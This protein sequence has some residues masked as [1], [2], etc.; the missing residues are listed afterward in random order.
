MKKIIVL[1]MSI[2]LVIN[3]YAQ[4]GFGGGG[5]GRGGGGFGGGQGGP[6]GGGSGGRPG[7]GMQNMQEEFV[8]EYFPEI[9]GLS[10]KQKKSVEKIMSDEQQSVRMLQRQ[11]RALFR[12]D[13]GR[14][15]QR[16][17]GSFGGGGQPGRFMPSEM[18][19]A[20]PDLSANPEDDADP[21][22]TPEQLEKARLKA[23][24]IDAKIAKRIEKSNKKIAKKLTPQQYD[25][26]LTKRGEFKF[27]R[28]RPDGMQQGGGR[29][30]RQQQSEGRGGI[31]PPA[32]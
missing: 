20:E 14:Q 2:T 32:E 21:S 5:G 17:G 18:R 26:F 13:D 7:G 25:S 4:G 11:K 29:G 23:A 12:K 9:E 15:P 28:K 3:G 22:L 24:K 1:L 31:G 8:V 10:A 30:E 19:Q 6:S 27:A 16:G